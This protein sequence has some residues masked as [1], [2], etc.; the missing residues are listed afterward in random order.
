MHAYYVA[1][2]RP[3]AESFFA[4]AKV[5]MQLDPNY[6]MPQSLW[7]ILK[8]YE[9]EACFVLMFWAFAIRAGASCRS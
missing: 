6:Q 9:Q 8:D 1:V 3:N 2:V 7:V 5:K 4:Q